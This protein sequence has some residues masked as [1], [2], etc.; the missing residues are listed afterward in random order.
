MKAGEVGDQGL[1]LHQPDAAPVQGGDQGREGGPGPIHQT[2]FQGQPE[3]L[4]RHQ[5]WRIRQGKYQQNSRRDHHLWTAVPAGIVHHQHQQ[6][7]VCWVKS[8]FEQ[9]QGSTERLH[10]H[11]IEAQQIGPAGV[12]VDE[13][14][15][16]RPFE[17]I[18]VRCGGARPPLGPAAVDHAL[19][20]QPRLILKP[21][22]NPPLWMRDF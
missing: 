18:V 2:F 19:G 8:N 14:I 4:G 5:F 12:R 6:T 1:L 21:Q 16:V 22:F 20:A 17:A 11:G 10:I 15:D 3:V 13:P 7:F 9:R